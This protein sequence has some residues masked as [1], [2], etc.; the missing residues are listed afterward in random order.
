MDMFVL[1]VRRSGG[2]GDERFAA[3]ITEDFGAALKAAREVET[4]GGYHG[5]YHPEDH[6]V[7]I[8]RLKPGVY[9]K[10]RSAAGP[11]DSIEHT[12]V[13]IRRPVRQPETAEYREAKAWT[14]EW[15]DHPLMLYHAPDGEYLPF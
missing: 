15:F 8:S 3:M 14:E 2:H 11:D 6:A 4:T 12:L 7:S 10:H 13:F 9:Y 1:E 5:F